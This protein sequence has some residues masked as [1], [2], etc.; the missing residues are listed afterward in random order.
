[1]S[2]KL[3]KELIIPKLTKEVNSS[4][5]YASL[6]QVYYSLILAQWF[7]ARYHSQNTDS[8]LRALEGRS[9]LDSNLVNLIDSK[10]LSSLTS[11][12]PWNKQD[13]FNQYQ[14]SFTKG[15][16][17]TK[18]TVYTPSGQV[19]R[20]YMSGGVTF[21][22]ITSS[23]IKSNLGIIPQTPF[24]E[25]LIATFTNDPASLNISVSS[26]I[27]STCWQGSYKGALDKIRS[28]PLGNNFVVKLF[29]HFAEPDDIVRLFDTIGIDKG[30]TVVDIGSGCKFQIAS[31]AALKAGR[32]I[33][34]DPMLEHGKIAFASGFHSFTDIIALSLNI[35][36]RA[37]GN[38]FIE[39]VAIENLNLDQIKPAKA[40]FLL[41]LLDYPGNP[42]SNQSIYESVMEIVNEGSSIIFTVDREDN[43]ADVLFSS[44]EKKGFRLVE[45]ESYEYLGYGATRFEVV[46]ANVVDS[47]PA[48]SA[49]GD[50]AA[51]NVV[52]N[53]L[54]KMILVEYWSALRKL[55]NPD[56]KELTVVVGAAG[57]SISDVW[58][59][60]HFKKAYF[61]DT[62]KVT[63]RRLNEC[64]DSWEG[65]GFDNSYFKFK[66][67]KGF[68]HRFEIKKFGIEYWL[69]S[70]LKAMG[71]KKEDI[72]IDSDEKRRPIIK[73]RLP[74]QANLKE[75]VF[76]KQNLERKSNLLNT[77]FQEKADI[78]YEKAS[79]SL[80]EN[81][82]KYLSIIQSWIKPAG[83]IMIDGRVG[84][85]HRSDNENR[86][87]KMF[88]S[89]DFHNFKKLTV[90]KQIEELSKFVFRER[91][92]GYGWELSI[93]QR[94]F[95]VS[96]AATVGRGQGAGD[97]NDAASSAVKKKIELSPV[98][99]A[100]FNS[101]AGSSAVMGE[102]FKSICAIAQR[103]NPDFN[104]KLLYEANQKDPSYEPKH[105]QDG[106][107]SIFM[108]R[109]DD[110]RLDEPEEWNRWPDYRG[111]ILSVD[112]E[113][114][115]AYLR[116]RF[117]IEGCYIEEDSRLYDYGGRH[118][119]LGALERNLFVPRE[120]EYFVQLCL[121]IGIAKMNK[122]IFGEDI[123]GEVKLGIRILG[124]DGDIPD[125]GNKE[126][127]FMI[128]KR[129]GLP[130]PSGIALSA[131]LVKKLLSKTDAEIEEY[132]EFMRKEAEQ[133]RIFFINIDEL[134]VRSNPRY[135]MPGILETSSDERLSIAQ[136]IRVVGNSW[137]SER[138]KKYRKKY[139]LENK[140][141]LSI[142]IQKQIRT[143]SPIHSDEDFCA[144]GVFSTHNPNTAEDRLCG[145]FIENGLGEELMTGGNSG[146][147]I[148][149]LERYQP[150]IYAQLM[151]AKRK[152]ENM[153]GPQEVEFAIQW[154]RVYFIQSRR[155]NFS[156]Q[157]EVVYLREQLR[158]GVISETKAIPR[159]EELQD[160]IGKRKLYRIK[161]DVELKP[162]A[163]GIG[164]TP[165]AIQ[166]Y[167][168]W[169]M[170]LAYKYMQQNLPVI[171][172]S[173]EQNREE[174]LDIIF[175]YPNSGLITNYGNDSS[176]EA[177]LA[178]KAG[179]PAIIN[180]QKANWDM[181]GEGIILEDG[182][183]L[184]E[185]DL[186]IIDGSNNQIAVSDNDV[187]EEDGII[188]DVSYGV[189][190][191][192][193][194]K[195]VLRVYL[196]DDG[197]IKTEF[198]VERLQELNN[199]AADRYEKL[200][201]SDNHQSAFIANLEKHFLHEL[202]LKAMEESSNSVF[203]NKPGVTAASSAVGKDISLLSS[204][205]ARLVHSKARKY[206]EKI[207]V[208]YELRYE[209]KR[210]TKRPANI[211]HLNNAIGSMGVN[212][213][214]RPEGIV[215]V[216]HAMKMLNL[217]PKELD[218]KD[219]GAGDGCFD[220][221]LAHVLG[222]KQVTAWEH[223]K[224]AKLH[225]ELLRLRDWADKEGL[226]TRSQIELVEGNFLNYKLDTKRH[227]ILYYYSDGSVESWKLEQKV[228][229][230]LNKGSC[231]V[232]YSPVWYRFAKLESIFKHYVVMHG[233][234][235]IGII[236]T[237][238]RISSA[239]SSAAGDT[240]G[241]ADEAASSAVGKTEQDSSDKVVEPYGP[242]RTIFRGL[243][244]EDAFTGVQVSCC[245]GEARKIAYA[246]GRKARILVV[247]AGAGRLIYELKENFPDVK[248][249]FINKE[250]IWLAKETEED[251]A[252]FA[253][254]LSKVRTDSYFEEVISVDEA[255]KF[256]SY[257][258]DNVTLHDVNKKLPFE[259]GSF[260]FVL[261]TYQTLNYIENK[262]ELVAEV[263]RV[264]RKEGVALI[265][266]FTNS[267]IVGVPNNVFFSQI[268]GGEYEFRVNDPKEE[269]GY[270][271][272]RNM[273]PD[274]SL[275]PH[276]ELNES[277]PIASSN[278]PPTYE[279]FYFVATPESASS[280]IRLASE[281]AVKN[282]LL[283]KDFIDYWQMFAQKVNPGSADLVVA[284][285]ASGADVSGAL[286]ATNF[287]KAYF[288]DNLPVRLDGL[289]VESLRRDRFVSF[290]NYLLTKFSNGYS[291]TEDIKDYGI[292]ALIMLELEALGVKKKDIDCDLDEQGRTKLTFRLPADE[293]PREIIFVQQDLINTNGKLN[294]E[295]KG[296]VD[297][298]FQKASVHLPIYYDRIINNVKNWIKDDGFMMIDCHMVYDTDVDVKKAISP[299]VLKEVIDKQI[300]EKVD[301]ILHKFMCYRYGWELSLWQKAKQ[302]LEAKMPGGLDGSASS[303]LIS[304]QGRAPG[305]ID[306]RSLPIVTQAMSN[307]GL[308]KVSPALRNQL[309]LLNVNVKLVEI[310]KLLNA[311]ITPSTER[312]KECA[313]AAYLFSHSQEENGKIISCIAQVLR[314][315]EE[316]CCSTDPILK[317]ILVVLE[318]GSV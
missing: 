63:V 103:I 110:T 308:N 183:V 61:I 261:V 33:A 279:N 109:N 1:Y 211:L 273:N 84:G 137:N 7:K 36:P 118:Y 133:E 190:I 228:L 142:I 240:N 143:R 113:I 65:M 179:I 259:N 307:L 88:D 236:F 51:M 73:F 27:N 30:D 34:V 316:G 153:V 11:K 191:S 75:I 166:G 242:W 98:V 40:V 230:E 15:E 235:R 252:R 200:E 295:L 244:L 169:N 120:Y 13:Y 299:F 237:G 26:A 87:M 202:L 31:F 18:E 83:F 55:V 157:A 317:D 78:Y 292:E 91:N 201:K 209:Q 215:L 297:I 231:F 311:G 253:A 6:R 318:A 149:D 286:F 32:V 293:R 156:P 298:Y 122:I 239:G 296:Q 246:E 47:Q 126:K 95:S 229:T 154:G 85:H 219:L 139:R 128:F 249:S 302:T 310:N 271:L 92:S 204:E 119:Y 189:N 232:I 68:A 167:L 69:I 243:D 49:V 132:F 247:G 41:N 291:S 194:R 9:N 171:F 256:R 315:Q 53:K 152:L 170:D 71:V 116:D 108:I 80:P 195:T 285:G 165:G 50:S 131:E 314:K 89:L 46:R 105:S 208:Y 270:L 181:Q 278:F 217:D 272:I 263:K 117:K 79:V 168:V 218:L 125:A 62:L 216:W 58:F 148:S 266:N 82:D 17:N 258:R 312:V 99:K 101:K 283:R 100:Y 197:L 289:L 277:I 306:F 274:N 313:Q 134:I 86:G 287:R 284:V 8:S 305:G 59:G 245:I 267:H 163:H 221:G 21:Q 5:R 145:R 178:R 72:S 257:F 12:T 193:Y 290:E 227:K 251:A 146:K 176:H 130:Y 114:S 280:A 140:E 90:N 150:K 205:E 162:L 255:R 102:E 48:S 175:D 224:N 104:Y 206:F 44:A 241:A 76:I 123:E 147:D 56:S 203:P 94:D 115:S 70:E 25:E 172:V 214:S 151:D 38:L 300:R 262:L 265:N 45:R 54:L 138:A 281:N 225:G 192:E 23:A 136:K 288:I 93:W 19:I 135:S 106:K 127:S 155:I 180:L 254:Y 282:G 184:R 260:D 10:N 198:T 144:A 42:G 97:T 161:K 233:D 269:N 303:S 276:L 196:N 74:G 20:S 250:N 39:P 186:I 173:S 22:Q 223:E 129:L 275:L 304:Q 4:K 24:T 160:L 234:T 3:I 159:I 52:K 29:V 264:L 158:K 37:F 222:L 67:E 112:A 212:A 185:K 43:D 248:L 2:T 111:K 141:E 199:Q 60:T 164:A 81:Y 35:S 174:V 77:E 107:F 64:R 294:D 220:V 207:K 187:L 57:P 96:S 124:K 301:N 268:P 14:Q 28:D 121:R 309:M 66:Y 182:A 16:Y 210:L 238:E 213:P 188:D 177:V 226:I